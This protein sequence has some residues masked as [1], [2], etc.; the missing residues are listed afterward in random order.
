MPSISITVRSFTSPSESEIAAAISAEPTIEDA[1]AAIKAEI[2][3]RVSTVP[4]TGASACT[5][6]RAMHA[7]SASCPRLK[8]S[9]TGGRRRSNSSTRPQPSRH[10][11]P[12]D[13]ALQK[14][15]PNTS[16]MSP[17]EKECAPRRKCRWTT[18]RSAIANAIAIAHHGRWGRASGGSP[19][20]GPA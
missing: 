15:S 1:W 4:L 9:L 12:N 8:T 17:S 16:G 14:M 5:T 6:S 7:C 11:I 18:Q 13:S 3:V 10:P 20:T 19:W 2:H